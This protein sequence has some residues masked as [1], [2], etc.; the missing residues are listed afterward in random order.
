MWEKTNSDP[1]V[2][3]SLCDDGS[4][5][6]CVH[7]GMSVFSDNHVSQ[8]TAT[9]HGKGLVLSISFYND[10]GSK[11]EIFLFFLSEKTIF[12]YLSTPEV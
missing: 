2:Q 11:L 12:T 3:D 7:R 9:F 5:V 4:R 6:L 10:I 1:K 8:K